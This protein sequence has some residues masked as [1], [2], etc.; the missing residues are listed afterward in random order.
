MLGFLFPSQQIFGRTGKQ[1]I[2]TTNF[3]RVRVGGIKANSEALLRACP[4]SFRLPK[5]KEET[6]GQVRGRGTKMD[7]EV[8]RGGGKNGG[9]KTEKERNIE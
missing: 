8:E 3:K 9:R 1:N 7:M 6:G 2:K 5:Q 4:S